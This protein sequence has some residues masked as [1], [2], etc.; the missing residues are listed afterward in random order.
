MSAAGPGGLPLLRDN[1]ED[2]R[3]LV[4]SAAAH[5]EL[6]PSFVEK[7]FWVTEVL[8]AATG[9]RTVVDKMGAVHEVRLIF[10]GGTSLSKVFGLIQRFSEDVDLLVEFPP[11]ADLSLK[12]RDGVLKGIC[13]GVQSHLSLSDEDCQRGNSTTGIKRDVRFLCPTGYDDAAITSGVLL[14]M[15]CRGGTYPTVDASLSSLLAIYAIGQLG[16]DRHAWAEY[17]PVPVVALG[18]E[19]TL[20]EKVALLHDAATR[21]TPDTPQRLLRAGRHLYDV[22]QL[23]GSARVRDALSAIGPDARR[24]LCDDIDA[25]SAGAGFSHSPRPPQGYAHSPAFDP[26]HPSQDA[27]RRGYEQALRLVHGPKPAFGECGDIV[28]KH[29]DLL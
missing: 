21:F 19:R 26:Q 20:L 23:L 14:E 15:G 27:A 8:R 12:A 29:A 4:S 13:A 2:L 3:A 6:D 24:A 9:P 28:R 7:D 16:D 1:P 18:P 22:H 17:A 5:L 10:K 11:D 25:H